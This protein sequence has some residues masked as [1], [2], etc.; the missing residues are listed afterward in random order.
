MNG[1]L[2]ILGVVS[3]NKN[4]VYVIEEN[5]NGFETSNHWRIS[6]KNNILTVENTTYER[7]VK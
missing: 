1:A 7:Y 3:Y 5:D 6:V 2:Y 4:A